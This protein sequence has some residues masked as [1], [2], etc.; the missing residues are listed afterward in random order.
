MEQ[1]Q[2]KRRIVSTILKSLLFMYIITGIF[3]LILA[4]MLSKLQLTEGAV[5]VGIVVI[6]VISG[7]LGGLFAGKKLKNRK[8]LW[9]MIMGAA[10]FLVL[11]LGS[12]IFH[13]GLEL[14]VGRI[15]TTL[16][17]CTASGMIGGMCA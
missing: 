10:Y 2:G 6:Y 14:D 7:F 11:V 8:F 5:T 3:L 1:M 15:V 16:I 13:R 4:A 17:L 9:G 12:V